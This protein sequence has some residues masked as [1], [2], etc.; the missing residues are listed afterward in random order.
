MAARDH[1][2]P[3][4]AGAAEARC[5]NWKSGSPNWKQIA[6]RRRSHAASRTAAAA[7]PTRTRSSWTAPD[8]RPLRILSEYLEPLAHFRRRED[9]RHDRVLRLGAH[10]ART[11]RWARY[12]DEA[13]ELARL[14]TEWSDTLPQPHAALRG[15]HR[16]RAGHH[17]GGQPRRARRRRQDH[18]AE[19][20]PALRAVPQSV[21]HAGAELRVPLLLHAQV[22]VRVPGQGAGGVSRAASAR[23]TS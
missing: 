18:R 14:L 16:R 12:Y 10:R 19:H 4:T 5:D 17:G 7:S 15:L 3:E 9:P 13:R 1:R 23:W 21:H 8:A 20:R 2:I 11:A 22:L 6:E